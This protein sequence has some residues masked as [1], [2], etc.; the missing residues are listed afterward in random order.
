MILALS[1]DLL[2]HMRFLH[3]SETGVESLKFES[4]SLVVHPQAVEDGRIHI[5]DVHRIFDDVVTI[6]VCG[7]MDV[8]TFDHSTRHPN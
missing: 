2:H 8:T 6:V 5:V 7:T 1:E 4:E 3:S